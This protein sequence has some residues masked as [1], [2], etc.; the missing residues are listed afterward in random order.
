M[1]FVIAAQAPDRQ[2]N[3]AMSEQDIKNYIQAHTPLLS[4]ARGGADASTIHLYNV[5]DFSKT[6]SE[7]LLT[8]VPVFDAA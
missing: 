6:H 5:S 2:G 4:N 3:Q 7:C 1:F 8:C